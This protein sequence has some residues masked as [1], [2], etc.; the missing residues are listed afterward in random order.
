MDMSIL[1]E[2]LTPDN[3]EKGVKFAT[4]A[5]TVK[6]LKNSETFNNIWDITIG[7][8]LEAWNQKSIF[9]NQQDVE[10]YKNDC[11]RK[12][13]QIPE[14]K[15]QEP[16]LSIAGPALEASKFYIEEEEIRN[17]FSNL[18]ASSMNSDYGDIPHSF[19]EIIKQLSPFDANLFQSLHDDDNTLAEFVLENERHHTYSLFQDIHISPNFVDFNKNSISLMNLQKQ[20]LIKILYGSYLTK[21]SAYEVYNHMQNEIEQGYSTLP[22]VDGLPTK[23]VMKK[24]K[25]QLTSLGKRFREICCK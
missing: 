19:V 24:H 16:K 15:F 3:I 4:S 5:S 25:F 20:G 11:I 10:K 12:M 21:D 13:S 6:F 9:K 8:K 22:Y 14:E 1:K 18:I 23:L 7:N 17:M 2:L